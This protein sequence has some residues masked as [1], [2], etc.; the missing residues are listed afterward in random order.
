MSLELRGLHGELLDQTNPEVITSQDGK[1]TPSGPTHTDELLS[2]LMLPYRRD[3][4]IPPEDITLGVYV[5]EMA[6]EAATK[7]HKATQRAI[8][9]LGQHEGETRDGNI[10]A[11]PRAE[12]AAHAVRHFLTMEV[13]YAQTAADFKQL[14]EYMD[15]V[16]G[17][18]HDVQPT[19]SGVTPQGVEK[20]EDDTLA[21]RYLD[22]M[23]G[24]R[25]SFEDWQPIV[26]WMALHREGGL[27]YL[28]EHSRHNA[29]LISMKGWSERFAGTAVGEKVD[30][31]LE[32]I[33]TML[34]YP[35]AF[36]LLDIVI[37][38]D[39]ILAPEPIQVPFTHSRK[40][41][42]L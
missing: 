3:E 20:L 39:S 16:L 18:F 33:G 24:F 10:H 26:D 19:Y 14:D 42:G 11:I 34:R 31:E 25:D 6:E 37:D 35:R 32:V 9:S 4:L 23:L 41:L 38:A 30:A 7:R 21:G 17:R 12:H 27:K 2:Q 29:D 13:R 15:V 28:D 5:E 36:N 40:E 8:M 22:T 1:S